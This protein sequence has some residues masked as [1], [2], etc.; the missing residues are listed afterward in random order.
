MGSKSVIATLLRFAKTCMQ[1]TFQTDFHLIL[2]D[3]I[4]PDALSR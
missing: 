4:Y 3:S 1:L 2:P